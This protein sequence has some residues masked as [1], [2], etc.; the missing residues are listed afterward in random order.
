MRAPRPLA[1]LAGMCL[2]FSVHAASHDVSSAADIAKWS[3]KLA[4]GDSLVMRDGEWKDQSISFT[5]K[6]TA[7][8]PI[9]LRAKTPGKVQLTGKSSLTIDGEYATASG[10]SIK[11]G[12]G[13]VAITIKGR[14]CRLTESAVTGGE[15]KNFVRFFNGTE[16]RMDHCYLA[17][18]TTESPTL[19]VE[20]EEHPNQHLI[21]HNHFGPRP[22]LGRNGGETMR[23]GYSDQSMRNSHTLVEENLFEGCDGEIEIISNKSCEN[24]YRHNTFLDCAGMLTLRHGNRCVVDGNFFIGHHKKSSGGIRII[25][26]GH[27]V[28]NNYLDGVY[29]GGFWITAGVPNSK[30]EEYFRAKDCLIAFNTMVDSTGPCLA[31]DEGFGTSK[32]SLRPENITIANNVFSIPVKGELMAGT[33]GANFKWLA[34]LATAATPPPAHAGVRVADPKLAKS[35]DGLFRP[36]PDSP[37]RKAA[38]GNF[39]LV[40]TDLNGTPRLVPA[41]LGCTQLDSPT[42]RRPLT[43]PDVGPAWLERKPAGSGKH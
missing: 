18:K 12:S 14:H 28:I 24:Y 19:Q 4:P 36:T 5:A 40:K 20:V 21:D 26:E 31:L 23:I 39:P 17:G 38:E 1:V 27:T 16:N 7:S 11:S 29:R 13:K 37:A 33:E 10:L 42:L 35:P 41:D 43:Q 15:Y 25:G 2:I 3:G 6:G 8:N 32:R 9:T 22:P 34:N 30:L